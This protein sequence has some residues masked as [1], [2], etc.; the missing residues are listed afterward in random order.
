MTDSPS[1]DPTPTRTQPAPGS[2]GNLERLRAL[3]HEMFQLDRGDLDFG[4]YRIMKLKAAEIES[5]LDDDLLP[6]VKK[7]LRRTSDNERAALERELEA[8]RETAR[9]LGANPDTAPLPKIVKLNER[10]SEK[11]SRDWRRWPET[12]TPACKA[13]ICS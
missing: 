10:L 6:Q 11:S 7:Q 4:L 12:A 2:E 8:A 3:L 5:F 9:E 13:E 1:S